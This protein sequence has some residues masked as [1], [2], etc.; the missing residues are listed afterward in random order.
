MRKRF[1]NNDLLQSIQ[2]AQLTVEQDKVIGAGVHSKGLIN[3][4]LSAGKLF[5][6][7]A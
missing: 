3:P 6:I 1:P 4:F 5:P 2:K 7:F